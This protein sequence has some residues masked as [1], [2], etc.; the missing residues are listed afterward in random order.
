MDKAKVLPNGWEEA[1][2]PRA[3]SWAVAI[4]STLLVAG[5]IHAA[6]LASQGYGMAMLQRQLKASLINESQASVVILDTRYEQLL[7]HE[8]G[9]VKAAREL[10]AALQ[11]GDL[12]RA[13]RILESSKN[14]PAVPSIT[15]TRGHVVAANEVINRKATLEDTQRTVAQKQL[16]AQQ[17][18]VLL[19]KDL[20]ALLGVSAQE[21]HGGQVALYQS[22]VLAGLPL[23][24]G[25][26]DA[27]K[28]MKELQ[29][30]VSRTVAETLV[31]VGAKNQQFTERLKDLRS[32]G[33]Q[34]QTEN[35]TLI[36]QAS[37]A[38]AA[39]DGHAAEVEA[40]VNACKSELVNI[41]LDIARP[42]LD[43]DVVDAYGRV[44]NWGKIAGVELPPLGRV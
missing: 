15:K 39:L 27:I 22:G 3:T 34:L 29:R 43:A 31:T 24:V 23:L 41:V 6:Q 17:L 9:R 38:T 35:A 25:V 5:C 16:R 26:P 32:R 4:G 20:G 18:A 33:Q 30:H 8:D 44:V 10:I 19:A 40:A 12:A 28:D 14:L 37:A 21:E 36:Q 13:G 11:L 7:P 2:T 42:K 1:D